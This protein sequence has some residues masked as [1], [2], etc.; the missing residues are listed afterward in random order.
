MKAIIDTYVYGRIGVD[1]IH[2]SVNINVES[3]AFKGYK[4]ERGR[5]ILI[6]EDPSAAEE[7]CRIFP[8]GKWTHTYF[9]EESTLRRSGS[10]RL[11]ICLE[12]E[13]DENSALIEFE[14]LTGP[15][16]EY[17]YGLYKKMF[18]FSK[19][20][21]LEEYYRDCIDDELLHPCFSESP[22]VGGLDKIFRENKGE[23]VRIRDMILEHKSEFIKP[24]SIEVDHEKVTSYL[25]KLVFDALVHYVKSGT[26]RERRKNERKTGKDMEGTGPR[27]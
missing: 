22:A 23:Y 18:P 25:S 7:I 3:L 4:E 14:D 12:V 19:V 10:T 11:Y 5:F 24:D 21:T 9:V 15:D 6:P 17:L 1:V 13:D 8:L 27:V 20:M 2:E 16:Y 26:Q